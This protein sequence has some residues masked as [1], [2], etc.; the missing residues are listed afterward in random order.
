[1][2]AY[3]ILAFTGPLACVILGTFTLL[4]DYRKTLNRLFFLMCVSLSGYMLFANLCY[5]ATSKEHIETLYKTSSF[6]FGS[7][8]AV[9]LH[10]NIIF[11]KN[12]L[13]LW[14]YIFLYLPVPVIVIATFTNFTI[15]SDFIFYNGRWEFIPAYRSIW[16]YFTI[17]SDLL[18]TAASILLIEK[19]R[20]KSVKNKVKRQAVIINASYITLMIIGP[21]STLVLPIFH[22][23]FLSALGVNCFFLYLLAIYYAVFKF[24]FLNLTPSI[25]GDEI[26]AHIS[27]MVFILDTDYKISM[28]NS[29]GTEVLNVPAENIKD[30][31]FFN[32]TAGNEKM[33]NKFGEL[34]NSKEKSLYCRLS[35]TGGREEIL[36]DSYISKI[37]D[38]LND[39]AGFLIISKENRGK[40]EFRNLYKITEREFEVIDLV[41]SGLPN[42]TISEKLGISERTVE[43]HRLH[44]Y[45][46]LGISDR[47]ELFTLADEFNLIPKK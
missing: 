19:Y 39:L 22:I 15:F 3:S 2:N 46:K 7:Y 6:F 36:T 44:V 24:R 30:R 25:M 40:T 13:K 20:R 14:Q 12:K 23:Y 47:I 18:Y 42:R 41:L 10:F 35:F 27:E 26:I 45:S 28:I 5:L 38:K 11:T 8:Y 34:L 32:I 1:M 4:Q 21:F 9:N 37:Y 43:A 31:S 29:K 33:K 16:F 17:I